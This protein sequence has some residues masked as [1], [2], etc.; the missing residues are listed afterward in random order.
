ML[1]VLLLKHSACATVDGPKFGNFRSRYT[2]NGNGAVPEYV[3]HVQGV[4]S[5]P[6]NKPEEGIK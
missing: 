6:V 1:I 5:G 3:L 2:R 4:S